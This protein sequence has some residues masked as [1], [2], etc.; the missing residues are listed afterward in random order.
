M[1]SMTA[2]GSTFVGAGDRA[3]IAAEKFATGGAASVDLRNS[4]AYHFP[5][6]VPTA[7]LEADGGVITAQHS[8]FTTR[9]EKEGGA[10]TPP[11]SGSNLIGD[12]Q[13]VDIANGNFA[14]RTTSPL[15]DR[16]DPSIVAPGQLDL[17]GAPRSLD[18]NGDCVAAPDIGALEVTGQAAPCPID[19]RPRVSGFRVTNKVFAPK[20]GS[21]KR[22][23]RAAST[24]GKRRRVK[25]GSKFTYTLSEPAKVTITIERKARGRK[26]KRGGRTRCVKP[27]RG[28]AKP[29]CVRWIRVGTLGA[30]KQAGRQTTPFSGRIKG[31]ALKPGRY[32]GRIV[33]TDAAGQASSPRQAGFRI[34]SG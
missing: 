32:R 16:G 25:R 14:L 24:S 19:A 23:R 28:K 29:R 27:R 31:R 34:V 15:I 3:V 2:R 11:G 26:V 18:G 21:K 22:K 7:D 5:E 12:P 13:F 4:I 6:E 1:A 8:N 20:G 17:A 10:V 30:R 9:V 33:A